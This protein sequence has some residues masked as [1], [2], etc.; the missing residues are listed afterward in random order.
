MDAVTLRHT[1]AAPSGQ[2]PAQGVQRGGIY[3]PDLHYEVMPEFFQ[4]QEMR[5]EDPASFPEKSVAKVSGSLG[6]PAPETALVN[7]GLQTL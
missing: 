1:K 2:M 3:G 5:K 6:C 7:L 4:R